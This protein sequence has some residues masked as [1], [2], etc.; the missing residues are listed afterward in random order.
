[1]KANIE[2]LDR[3]TAYERYPHLF[4]LDDEGEFDYGSYSE[5]IHGFRGDWVYTMPTDFLVITSEDGELL[6]FLD[7]D[8]ARFTEVS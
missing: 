5:V 4:I 2:I 8:Y 1:M 6:Y 7:G 3:G